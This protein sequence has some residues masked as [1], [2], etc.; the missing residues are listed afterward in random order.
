MNIKTTFFI[1]A[2]FLFACS[3]K[4]KSY[5]PLPEHPRPNFQRAVWQNLNGYWDFK[6]DSNNVGL[7]E[8]WQIQ[9]GSFDREILVPFSWAAPLSEVECPMWM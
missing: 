9:T 8:N 2:V 1:L 5:V 3:Q 4:D 6:P 7:D